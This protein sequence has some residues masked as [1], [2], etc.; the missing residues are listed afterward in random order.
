MSEDW[1]WSAEN[2]PQDWASN[3]YSLLLYPISLITFLMILSWS[4]MELVLI[5]PATTT[6][7]VVTN[8]SHATF[9]FLSKA[10]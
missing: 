9:E 6:W 8:V 3:W 10:K 5:S 2:I 7:P 4:I 1:E